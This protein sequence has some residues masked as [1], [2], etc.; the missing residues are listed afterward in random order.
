MNTDLGA[1]IFSMCAFAFVCLGTLGIGAVLLVRFTG[2]SILPALFE[3]AGLGD[4]DSD[5]VSQSETSRKA[6]ADIPTARKL[7]QKAQ[8]VSFD[9]ALRRHSDG[10]IGQTSDPSLSPSKHRSQSVDPLKPENRPVLP[11]APGEGFSNLDDVKPR[12]LR[13]RDTRR[14]ED[15]TYYDDS[16]ADGL[17]EFFN[18]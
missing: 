5:N 9:A 2:M 4:D 16:D 15:S 18:L 8:D 14:R 3:M 6:G 13:R 12:N 10:D 11:D 17:D 7:R 1:I